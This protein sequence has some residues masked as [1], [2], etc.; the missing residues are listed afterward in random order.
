M[1]TLYRINV[2]FDLGVPEEQ[3]AADFLK[4]LSATDKKSRNQFTIDA[5][6]AHI[7]QTKTER[8]FTLDDIQRVVREE[9]RSVSLIAPAPESTKVPELTK[10]QKEENARN[11]LLDL[12]MFG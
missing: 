11:V 5:V 1:N 8:D 3:Q 2:R 7:Q 10:E 6:I 4:G 12:E 9:L